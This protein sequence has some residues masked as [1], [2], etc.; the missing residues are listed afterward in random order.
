MAG[1]AR[2]KLLLRKVLHEPLGYVASL[3]LAVALLICA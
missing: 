3:R 1:L 2:R